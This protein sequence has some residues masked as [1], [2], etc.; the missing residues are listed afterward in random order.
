MLLHQV[1]KYKEGGREQR[2]VL[3]KKKLIKIK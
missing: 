3:T 2:S 1:D